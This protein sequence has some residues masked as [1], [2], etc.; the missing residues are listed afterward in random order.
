MTVINEDT[1]NCSGV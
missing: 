1:Y